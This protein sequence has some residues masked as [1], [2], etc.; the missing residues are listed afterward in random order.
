MNEE[1]RKKLNESS[2][3]DYDEQDLQLKVFGFKKNRTL[4]RK[5]SEQDE[6]GK[7]E[8]ESDEK[9]FCSQDENYEKVEKEQDLENLVF[10][11]IESSIITNIDKLYK[12]DK[13]PIIKK[14]LNNLEKTCLASHFERKPAWNDDAD[15][16]IVDLDQFNQFSNGH[17]KKTD[18]ITSSQ[19]EESLK[20]RYK[21]FYGTPVWADLEFNKTKKNNQNDRRKIESEIDSEEEEYVEDEIFHHTGTLLADK[22]KFKGPIPKGLIDIKVCTDA[23]YEEPSQSRLKSVEFHPTARVLLTAGLDQKLKLFQIDG[24]KNPKI[25]SIFVEKFPILSAHFTRN[26]EEIIMGSRHKNFY[27]YDMIAGKMVT[28]VPPVKAIDE[29]QKRSISSNFEISP[30]NSVCAFIGTQ[31]QIHLFSVKSKEWIDTLKINGECNCIAFSSDSRYIFAFGDDKDVN[32]F[33]MNDRGHRCFQKFSDFGCLSGTALAVSEN[34]QFLAT[35]C[36]SGVVNLYNL[37]ELTLNSPNKNPKPL[38][39]FLNLTTPCTGLKFNS[40]SELLA[41]CSS[42]AENAF[43]I[44]HTSSLSIMQNFPIQNQDRS[45]FT[46]MRIPQCFDFSLNS[47]YLAI[48]NQKG[49]ALLY[50]LKHYNGP[51]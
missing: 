36:K 6:S 48:G 5:N 33:D 30:N 39:S 4:L 21:K 24:K 11:S 14:K 49:N 34:S 51:Y 12:K 31:G 43:K 9:I 18:Q 2:D 1:K 46:P 8:I 35:G 3:E 23:N 41:T 25:Q 17:N 47:C 26:G 22:T 13:N 42:H 45:V 7:E 10:G 44:I 27:Y 16:E 50:R 40:T 19:V 28:V 20:A 37:N 15:N 29:Y 38:K 32:I